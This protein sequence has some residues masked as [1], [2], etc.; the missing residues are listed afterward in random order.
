MSFCRKSKNLASLTWL[1]AKHAKPWLGR[2]FVSGHSWAD[3]RRYT[4]KREHSFAW[5]TSRFLGK[6]KEGRRRYREPL[7]SA[8]RSKAALNPSDYTA[9][10]SNPLLNLRNAHCS[11]G[12]SMSSVLSFAGVSQLKT[13]SLVSPEKCSLL[14]RIVLACVK[15]F[16]GTKS[17]SVEVT[18]ADPRVCVIARSAAQVWTSALRS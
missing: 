13:I 5:P 18:I 7:Q 15:M 17:C 2:S 12:H 8:L 3:V 1:P 9:R 4:V 6:D 16:R 11:I 10:R 14:G